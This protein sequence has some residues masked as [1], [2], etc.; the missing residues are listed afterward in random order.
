MKPPE[1]LTVK[2]K[3]QSIHSVRSFDFTTNFGLAVFVAM[4]NLPNRDDFL[5]LL[6]GTHSPCCGAGIRVSLQGDRFYCM[7]CG[8][9]IPLH[10]YHGPQGFEHGLNRGLKLAFPQTVLDE[11]SVLSIL[12]PLTTAL[13]LDALQNLVGEAV[14]QGLWRRDSPEHLHWEL[15]LAVAP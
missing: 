13:A 14:E 10:S 9:L 8:E 4:A 2:A 11:L 1:P 5:G 7:G 3:R 6:M 15:H 12:D